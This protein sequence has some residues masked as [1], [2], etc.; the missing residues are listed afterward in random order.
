MEAV[1]ASRKEAVV[2]ERSSQVEIELCSGCLSKLSVQSAM[3]NDDEDYNVSSEVQRNLVNSRFRQ[4][5]RSFNGDGG[6]QRGA[7]FHTLSRIS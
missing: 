2:F 1:E 4:A 5:W 6:A 3:L 7:Y